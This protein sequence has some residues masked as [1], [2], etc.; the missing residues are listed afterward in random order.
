MSIIAGVFLKERTA[1][2]AEQ[3][4][5]ALKKAVLL[6]TGQEPDTYASGGAFLVKVDFGCF[7]R[8]AFLNDA[9]GNLS[10]LA[11]WPLLE[12]TRPLDRSEELR[13]L[14]QAMGDDREQMLARSTGNF[15]A[16]FYRKRDNVLDLVAG[17]AA[18][19]PV[20]YHEDGRRVV[21]SSM[22]KVLEKLASVPKRMDLRGITEMCTFSVPLADRTAYA[23]IR[24]VRAGHFVRFGARPT[25]AT[26]YFRWDAVDHSP[27]SQRKLRESVAEAL[28]RAVI[29]RLGKDRCVIS[30]LSG[31]LDSRTVVAHLR[32]MERE[33]HTFNFGP[34]GSLDAVLGEM[35]SK[36]A[37]TRHVGAPLSLDGTQSFIPAMRRQL[38]LVALNP[39]PERPALIWD[40]GGTGLTLM[41]HKLT[42][43]GVELLRQGK[44]E[45]A[46]RQII[47]EKQMLL[48]RRAFPSG[49]YA[50]LSNL[51]L[52]GLLEEMDRIR[53]GDL[54]RDYQVLMIHSYEGK[55]YYNLFEDMGEYRFELISPFLDWRFV[56]TCFRIPVEQAMWHRFYIPLLRAMPPSI[57]RVPWQAYPKSPPCPLP[58]PPAL[59][60][61]SKAN[62]YHL[63]DKAKW[64]KEG[65]T[66]LRKGKFAPPILRKDFLIWSVLANAVGIKDYGYVTRAW[67][68]F[69]HF[70]EVSGGKFVLP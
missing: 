34:V 38:D 33:V 41:L 54:L 39:R 23:D 7:L 46:L 18:L 31:G 45:E 32:A 52:E 66:L 4:S 51:L 36:E 50:K 24:T 70:H 65:W 1:I 17:K 25:R 56:E 57:R 12:D 29:R 62:P 13:L 49:V 19:R 43:R 63:A 20:Y 60:Q 48:P 2:I 15:C 14:A 42:E 21:F 44:R 30:F 58:L 8:N 16:A 28:Q 26:A 22:L 27:Q 10:L 40:G 11:G 35:F 64:R 47:R 3:E 5:S 9:E 67:S 61:W 37:G 55:H 6:A 59:N 53:S 69:S 68:S